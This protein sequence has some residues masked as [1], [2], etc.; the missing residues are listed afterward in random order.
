MIFDIKAENPPLISLY[1]G[2]AYKK[3]WL[4]KKMLMLTSITIPSI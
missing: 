3:R 4:A 2:M 1:V